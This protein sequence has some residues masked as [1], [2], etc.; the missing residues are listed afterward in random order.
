MPESMIVHEYRKRAVTFLESVTPARYDSPEAHRVCQRRQ[1][2]RG[3]SGCADLAHAMFEALG[4]RGY[5]V[6]RAPTWR[7]GWNVSLLAS[8]PGVS[9]TTID[10]GAVDGG[11]VLIQWARPDTTD[12]HVVCVLA[13]H[14][15]GTLSTA[16]Y[17][18]A[19]PLIGRQCT[20]DRSG[21]KRPWQV[22]L[23]LGAVLAASGV[24]I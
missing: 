16:E 14:A 22:W 18:Q 12:A 11:D 10:W 24:S 8:W 21:G 23:P 9:R 2:M 5:H 15:D 20:R 13:S 17:G 1:L 4:L 6:N 19:P 7:V 3:Y